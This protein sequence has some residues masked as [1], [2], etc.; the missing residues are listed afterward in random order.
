MKSKL[1][2]ACLLAT[3]AQAPH[4]LAQAVGTVTYFGVINNTQDINGYYEP[5]NDVD[6]A[7]LF[8]GGNL[9]GDFVSVTF[10]YNTA[11]GDTSTTPGVEAEAY[12]GSLIS[13]TSISPITSISFSVQQVITNN[14]YTYTFTPDYS[15]TLVTGPGEIEDIAQSTVGDNI[16]TYIESGF[17][18][19]DAPAD[20]SQ[21]YASYGFGP[22][23][24]FITGGSNTGTPDTI[25][26]DTS[27][28][29][30]SAV[31]TAPEP[32]AWALMI[33]GI[34]AAGLG[35]RSRRSRTISSGDLAV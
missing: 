11:L 2:T 29:I 14:I 32:S 22:G 34:G 30:V 10:T 5:G 12:G 16:T 6:Y 35:L 31:S 21:S 3:L 33:A 13:P 26:F 24:Y 17:S 19:L 18:Y 27:S 7:D 9:E 1:A 28:V 20:L 15:G 25:V 23:S 4:A 8:G